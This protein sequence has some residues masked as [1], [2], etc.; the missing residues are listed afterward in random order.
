M[1]NPASC[2]LVLALLPSCGDAEPPRR[3][4]GEV[5]GVDAICREGLE[6]RRISPESDNRRQC[7][8]PCDLFAANPHAPCEKFSKGARCSSGLCMRSCEGGCPDFT[9]CRPFGMVCE[10]Y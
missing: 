5:C 6:C 9:I 1:N 4:L 10:A 2:A 3:E 8:T 7:T